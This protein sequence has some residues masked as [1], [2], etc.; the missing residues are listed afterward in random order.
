MTKKILDTLI[1]H[2]LATSILVVDFFILAL[3]KPPFLFSLLMLGGP[4]AVCM[5]LGQRMSA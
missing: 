4:V 2:P 5:Y 3:H 1:E